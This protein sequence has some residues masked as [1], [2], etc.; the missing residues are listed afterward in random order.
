M[1]AYST[2][3]GCKNSVNDGTREKLQMVDSMQQLMI[4]G[5]G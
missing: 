1:I 2:G 4:H 5:G 3:Q